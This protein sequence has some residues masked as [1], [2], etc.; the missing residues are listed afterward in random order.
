[1]K[2]ITDN[3]IAQKDPDD[4][5]YDPLERWDAARMLY[6]ESPEALP[7]YTPRPKVF[8]AGGITD[9]EDWQAYVSHRLY[10]ITPLTLINPRRANF[11]MDD[12]SAA[13]EQIKWEWNMLR[14][15]DAIAFWFPKETLCPI[16]LY[17]L[18]TW[19]AI[20]GTHRKRILVGTDPDYQRRQDV[21]IQTGLVRPEVTVVDS[22][23]ALVDQIRAVRPLE[24]R[25]A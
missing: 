6:I 23:D 5:F 16:T 21:V 3:R 12:P 22:I 8:L 2:V 18:G 17:E 11:P 10:H 20:S 1:M 13:E 4:K 25:P 14:A 19:S 9:C 15:S 24:E 7:I